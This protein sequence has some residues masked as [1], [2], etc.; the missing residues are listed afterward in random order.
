[1]K[2]NKLLILSAAIQ[3]LL[4]TGVTQSANAADDHSGGA[5]QAAPSEENLDMKARIE[6]RKKEVEKEIA[7]EAQKKNGYY[8]EARSYGTKRI[9]TQPPEYAVGLNKTGIDAFRDITW[10]EVGFEQRSRYEYR[11]DDIRR[12][13][14]RPDAGPAAK[15]AYSGGLDQPLLF[16]THAYLG[17]KDILDP[18]RF[19]VEIQ[20]SRRYNSHYE[21][22][23]R[24]V[25][26]F[27]F[28]SAYGELFFK[29]A[30][31]KDDLGNNRPLSIKAGRLNFEFLDRRLIGFNNWRNTTNTFQ[32]FQVAL[33]E[34][35]NDW[36]LDLL[37]VQPLDRLKYNT[38]KPIEQQWFYGV[39]G[40]W[41]KWSNWI[42]LE[43]YYLGLRK[44]DTNDP[45]GLDNRDI[46]ATALRAYGFVPGT[47]FDWDLDAI[48]Q[49]GRH[50]NRNNGKSEEHEAF[51]MTAEV[52][53]T[54]DHPWKPR[55]SAMYGYA[56]GDKDPNDSQNNR[57]ERFFGFARPWS[58]D[59]YL[60]FENVS[61]PKI[62][63]E[64]KPHKK[65]SFDT[66]FSL[67]WLASDKDRFNN[68]FSVSNANDFNRDR[69]G[70]SGDYLG[71][72]I[73]VRLRYEPFAHVKT[74]FGYSHFTTGDFVRNR[75][76]A[77]NGGIAG[78]FTDDTD[79]FYVEITLNA[80]K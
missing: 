63:L 18:F 27:E 19:G 62:R 30:L 55:L 69:T 36:A 29:D 56:S 1:M 48:Y 38:D 49:F 32:G 37:A 40:H 53:Y 66:A 21:P 41:R 44:E 8:K 12:S 23:N 70:Q 16:K 39:I 34:D 73:D 33:G 61:V 26:E 9:K 3:G 57:F 58:S 5:A 76:V 45:G 47:G 6:A 20:D 67:Y 74:N 71:N 65:V 77:S 46:H 64:M 78:T 35:K 68:L 51:G 2:F 13:N 25:N 43:P 60:V 10:L 14:Y 4:A 72:S 80:F 52:G 42:T 50:A 31:G 54:F 75:M 11:D 59:D 17:L 24:D 28:I 22:D 79:F 7:E 15:R